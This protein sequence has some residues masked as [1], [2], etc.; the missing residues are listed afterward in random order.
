MLAKTVI[1]Q[2]VTYLNFYMA[3]GGT[4]F[5][6]AAKNL[7]TTYDYAAPV[8][9]PGGLWEKYYAARG[10]GLS[11]GMLGPILTRATQV[12]GGVECT[13]PAVSVTERIGGKSGALFVRENANAEQHYKMIF[14]DPESPTHRSVSVPRQGELVIGA[15]EMK[16]LPCRS[17]F[18]AASFVTRPLKWRRQA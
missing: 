2:G 4:N 8:R 5:D 7:T 17:P 9:E 10:I 13:N 15:R 1:E 6:W 14:Q 16:M 18:P 12:Q 3:S 11:L